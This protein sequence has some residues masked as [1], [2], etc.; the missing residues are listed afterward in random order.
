[1]PPAPGPSLRLRQVQRQT[2]TMTPALQQS[3]RL[4]QL[5]ADELGEAVKEAIESNPLLQPEEV[6]APPAAPEPPPR[7]Q[8]R[9]D[10]GFRPYN[11][12]AAALGGRRSGQRPDGGGDGGGD[13][14]MAEPAGDTLDATLN[15]EIAFG[16][17]TETERAVAQMLAGLLDEAGYLA[18][19]VEEVA[20][21]CDAS[22]ATVEAVLAR[23]QSI[24]GTGLF[25]RTLAE[26][27]ALQLEA[28]GA[29]DAPMQALLDNLELVAAG[30]VD[31]LARLAG[32]DDAAVV[33][34]IA[35]IRTL[36]PRPGLSAGGATA[37]TVIPDLLMSR[38]RKGTPLDASRAV[39]IGDW[40]LE[41]NPELQPR[42]GID[43]GQYSALRSATRKSEERS[44]LSERMREARWLL[45]TLDF[46]AAA[47][48]KI[49]AAIVSRQA[50]FFESGVNGLHPLTRREVAEAAEVHE[51]TV[52][53]AVTGKYLASPQG[54]FE[55]DWFFS[56]A[57]PDSTGGPPHSAR[58]VRRRIRDLI[59]AEDTPLS[60]AALA[61]QL[62]D[63]GF[64]LARRTV[65]KYRETLG[66]AASAQ[67]R[68]WRR[69]RSAGDP[70]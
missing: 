36:D 20:A 68:R 33:A 19:S 32:V 29:L 55:L 66:I 58:R 8:P 42:V 62:H 69:L 22:A 61:R 9:S 3:L 24:F 47:I 2:L 45:R 26:C 10:L 13:G 37:T 34:M 59:R 53:R 30:R 40:L 52:S 67:R 63:E 54:T 21:A 5:S 14:G 31:R 50:D 60:D 70:G 15:E 39:R 41:I 11:Q 28:R 1:M 12:L 6:E 48:L 44:Y 57:I 23:L 7:P 38:Y 16:F 46:R 43:E 17:A 51:S 65:A 49:G 18:G 35:E 27:L 25:A 4:L 56:A 64:A